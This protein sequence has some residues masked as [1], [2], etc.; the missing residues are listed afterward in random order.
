MALKL[1]KV[2]QDMA[3]R[4]V[5]APGEAAQVPLVFPEGIHSRAVQHF[6][7]Q[8]TAHWFFCI[9]YGPVPRE[10]EGRRVEKHPH[11]QL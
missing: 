9:I 1:P 3:G 8:S 4:G 10:E 7:F 5:R 6:A 2:S 11:T